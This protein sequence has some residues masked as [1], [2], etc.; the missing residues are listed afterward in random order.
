MIILDTDIV[1]L[2]ALGHE[3]VNAK[4]EEHGGAEE[5]AVTIITRMEILRGRFDSIIKAADEKFRGTPRKR[6]ISVD[7]SLKLGEHSIYN[8]YPGAMGCSQ[9][10]AMP[11]VWPS[12]T[13]RRLLLRPLPFPHSSRSASETGCCTFASCERRPVRT[14]DSFLGYS[15]RLPS[16]RH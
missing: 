15:V 4:V 2:Y 6:G 1:T 3:I 5:L 9:F 10:G 14:S 12:F 11:P 16:R 8:V 13:V 7:E